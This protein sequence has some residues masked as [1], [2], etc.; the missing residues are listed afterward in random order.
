MRKQEKKAAKRFYIAWRG[1]IREHNKKGYVISYFMGGWT[2]MTDEQAVYLLGKLTK[3]ER[4]EIM[5]YPIWQ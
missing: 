1:L 3:K 4:R 2:A 5:T